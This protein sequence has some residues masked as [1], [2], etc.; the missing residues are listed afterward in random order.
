MG[1]INHQPTSHVSLTLTVPAAQALSNALVALWEGNSE[2]ENVVMLTG[3]TAFG[4]GRAHLRIASACFGSV[5]DQLT[6]VRS[7]ISKVLDTL[8][9]PQ[10]QPF[11]L[12]IVG[13]TTAFIELL[14]GLKMLPDSEATRRAIKATQDEGY[15]GM[16]Y[17][18]GDLIDKAIGAADVLHNE[19]E[20]MVDGPEGGQGYFW[21]N[22]EAGNNGWRQCFFAAMTALT[23]LVTLW[24]TT[25]AI[26]T[27]A[28]L[29]GA[30]GKS[31]LDRVPAQ[32]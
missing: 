2:I 23:E 27:Q 24:A 14:V 19:T 12:A 3:N 16:F 29:V 8:A 32:I 15:R 13:D 22:V 20:S 4:A 1:G 31:L 17:A 9:D 10:Y 5:V 11:D 21:S 30:H 18:I 25:G 6:I 26:C 7:F 28:H